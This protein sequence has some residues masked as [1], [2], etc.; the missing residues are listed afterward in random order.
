MNRYFSNNVGNEYACMSVHLAVKLTSQQQ[1]K[2]KLY[3]KTNSMPR[4]LG[5]NCGHIYAAVTIL[6][7]DWKLY[8][9][10]WNISMWNLLLVALTETIHLYK[11]D[12]R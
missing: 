8:S 9:S 7:R 11:E 6:H 1:H 10:E 3:L 2:I 12:L 5:L 4:S